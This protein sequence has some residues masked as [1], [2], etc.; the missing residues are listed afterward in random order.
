MSRIFCHKLLVLPL[1][2]CI[3][4]MFCNKSVVKIVYVTYYVIKMLYGSDSNITICHAY[5]V[6]N[7]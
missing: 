3:Y 2:E 7:Y 4:G 5:F 1:V 6:I